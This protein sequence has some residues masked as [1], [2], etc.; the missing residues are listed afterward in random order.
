MLE[1]MLFPPTFV[2]ETPCASSL[3]CGLILEELA[4]LALTVD[5][6]E[7]K[8]ISFNGEVLK[9]ILFVPIQLME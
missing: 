6:D 4:T 5:D 8:L 3:F 7:E 9:K 1:I 2:E